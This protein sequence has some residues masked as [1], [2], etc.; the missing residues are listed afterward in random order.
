MRLTQ[1]AVCVCVMVLFSGGLRGASVVTAQTPPTVAVV[2]FYLLSPAAPLLGVV[3][4]WFAA[5]D[6]S[7]MLA[8]AGKGQLDLVPRPGVLRAERDIAWQ[9]ADVLHY[10]RLAELAGRL[11]ADRLVVG[12]IRQLNV[13]RDPG[14]AF[15]HL[16][17]G[18]TLA[19]AVITVQ[20]FDA[21]QG[22]IVAEIHATGDAVGSVRS[23]LAK[24][25]LHRA[26]QPT[27]RP[28]VSGLT[29]PEP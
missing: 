11:Q 4:E 29:A 1:Q 28:L 17:S 26:L 10:A 6:L 12:W 15:P 22:R 23:W 14:A 27:I 2:D 13:E 9:E 16:G 20:I 18:L 3:P 19:D 24:Q 25:V 7:V 5:D 21:R 8:R